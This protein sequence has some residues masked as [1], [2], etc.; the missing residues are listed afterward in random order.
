MPR[1]R[2]VQPRQI[3]PDP[4]YNSRIVAKL[5]NVVMRDGKKSIAQKHVYQAFAQIKQRGKD[6]LEV[7]QLA[8]DNVAPLKQVRP[9]R[10]G[11]ASYLVP[12]P[13]RGNQRLS[14]A[15]RW[16]VEAAN[17]RSNAEYKTFTNKLAAELVDAAEGKG[18]AVE[19]KETIH[20]IAE[21]NKAFAHFR[22]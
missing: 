21:A 18:G 12:T 2:R 3:D 16:L 4:L 19:K 20:K 8:I 11:G 5:I 15:I 7:L 6:P 13:V 1:S 14:L 10:V 9:R 22:W 17:A